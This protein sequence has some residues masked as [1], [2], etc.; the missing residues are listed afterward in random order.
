M[1]SPRRP[2]RLPFLLLGALSA[3]APPA[4]ADPLCARVG[5]AAYTATRTV[6]PPGGR[7]LTQRVAVDGD[8]VRIEATR[9][10]G[11]TTVTLLTRDLRALFD[12]LSPQ[13]TALR[14][15]PPAPPQIPPEAQRVREERAGGAVVLINEV[16]DDGGVWREI[17]RHR[18]RA[19]GVLLESRQVSPQGV[20][21]IR[22]SDIRPGRPD[23][24]AFELPPG[25]RLIDPPP[26]PA[27]GGMPGGAPG[28]APPRR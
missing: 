22:Q 26:M 20:V 4:L 28:G 1:A 5:S 16:V 11:G 23:P 3:G 12:P 6:T 10:D 13:R 24:S 19:D 25:F 18:C 14:L 8:R 2:S 27:Q 15:A 7:A 21:E 9:P 17:S